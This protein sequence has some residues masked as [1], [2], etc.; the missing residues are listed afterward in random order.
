[1]AL[2]TGAFGAL[3]RATVQGLAAAGWRVAALDVAPAAPAGLPASLAL[4]GVRLDD[5]AAAVAAVARTVAE[6]G[7]L[8]ALVNIAGGFAWETV[9]GGSAAT[10][11]RQHELNLMTALIACEAA[12]PH[13]A[14]SP[15]GR[16]VNVGAAAAGRA[17]KGMGAYTAAKSGVLR[18]TEALAEE[19]KDGRATVNA[20]LPSIL[21]TPANRAEMGEADAGRW[22]RPE[23]LAGVIAF[24]LSEAGAPIHGAAVPVTGRV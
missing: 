11:R 19:L 3:G 20:V 22:V 12:L 8:D 14:A 10:W 17:G 13:V 7:R 23:A 6:L 5:E 9:A 21:D 18:L 4:P 2:V 16:I 1:M 24:L 15:R